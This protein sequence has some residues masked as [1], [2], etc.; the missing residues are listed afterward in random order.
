MIVPYPFFTDWIKSSSW[1][2]SEKSRMCL[3]RSLTGHRNSTF[4]PF[5]PP[6]TGQIHRRSVA[7]TPF[8]TVSEEVFS[9]VCIAPVQP[10]VR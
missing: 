3:Q 6:N 5:W 1:K 2:L 10:R 7:H 8:R 4:R 9:E